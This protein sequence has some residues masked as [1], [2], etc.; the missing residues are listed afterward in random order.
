MKTAGRTVQR[1][2][3]VLLMLAVVGCEESAVPSPAPIP[4]AEVSV[5][6]SIV[7]AERLSVLGTVLPAQR[8]MLG[9]TTS[10]PVYVV[11]VRAGMEVKEGDVLAELGTADLELAVQEAED[12]LALSQALLEQAG[13]GA[14][15]QELDIAEAEYQRAVAQHQQLLTGAREQEAAA[16]QADCQAAWARHEQVKAGAGQQELIVAQASVEK[17]EAALQRAQAAYDAVAWRPDLEASPQAAALHEATIDY[18]AAGAEYERLRGLPGEADLQAAKAELARAEAQLELVQAGPTEHEVIASAS[19]VSIAQAQLALKEAGP[20]PE[21][22]AV[23]EARVQQARTA[24][25][26]ATL[27]LSRAR[28]MAP[29]D[30]TVSAVY[31]SPSEWAGPSVPIVELLDTS[32]WCVETRNVGELDI[33][34][35]QVGQEAVVRVLAFR[36]QALRGRVAAISPDAVVQQG[37][38]TYTVGIELEATDLDLRTGMNVEVE[39]L[40]R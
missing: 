4:A 20:R 2:F 35:V 40:T 12:A 28:L 21:D 34:R 24:L 13:A 16:A 23:G 32:R 31:A 3:L 29:F 11:R 30:G 22:V 6:S 14:R 7:E 38:T 17:A 19:S 10:G 36:D 5:G 1:T 18:Q 9:F 8:V 27:A 37:D 15:E 33:G 26:R 25:A 39:I